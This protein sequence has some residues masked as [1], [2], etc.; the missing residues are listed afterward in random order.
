MT[1]AKM[2]TRDLVPWDEDDGRSRDH[3]VSMHGWQ[4]V[5]VLARASHL[6]VL[7]RFE[8]CEA[9]FGLVQ[10]NHDHETGISPMASPPNRQEW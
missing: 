8:H 1:A 2:A 9:S 7:H 5:D 3:L 6:D 4:A 10:L